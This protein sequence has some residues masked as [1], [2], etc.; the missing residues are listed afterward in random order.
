LNI[1][2][3]PIPSARVP[4]YLNTGREPTTMQMMKITG[5]SKTRYKSPTNRLFEIIELN[6][7][8]PVIIWLEVTSK[9]LNITF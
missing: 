9:I 3:N 4:S 5:I 6:V 1:F 8:E 2:Q 7:D